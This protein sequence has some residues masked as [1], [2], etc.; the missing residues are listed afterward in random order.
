MA[1]RMSAR[2]RAW[3]RRALVLGCAVL[4]ACALGDWEES[5]YGSFSAARLATLETGWIPEILPEHATDISEVH[6][7]HSGGMYGCF[8]TVAAELAEVRSLAARAG[9]VRVNSRTLPAPPRRV[10]GRGRPWWPSELRDP[11][12][13]VYELPE[14]GAQSIFV[15]VLPSGRV[16]FAREAA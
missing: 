6:N 2:G 11:A 7:I 16:C 1:A 8:T 4:A 12:R 9:G 3:R 14:K 5:S 10:S 13:E 15:A